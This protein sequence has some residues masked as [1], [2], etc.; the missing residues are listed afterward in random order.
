[1]KAGIQA[2][3]GCLDA[4][5]S[6]YGAGSSGPDD[7]MTE[8]VDV[9]HTLRPSPVRHYRLTALM[10]LAA[11]VVHNDLVNNLSARNAPPAEKVIGLTEELF[12][13]HDPAAFVTSHSASPPG[14]EPDFPLI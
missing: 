10:L 11:S 5:V 8:F 3:Q 7:G 13:G 14:E 6:T 4:S 12:V 9:Q 2:F 1:V